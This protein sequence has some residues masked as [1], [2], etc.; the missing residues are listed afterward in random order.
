[1]NILVY[2]KIKLMEFPEDDLLR[3]IMV[4]LKKVYKNDSLM[5]GFGFFRDT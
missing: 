1:M 5:E 2:S 4:N 3:S